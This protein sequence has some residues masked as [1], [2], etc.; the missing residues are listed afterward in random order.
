MSFKFKKL[1]FS[2]YMAKLES[3]V[4]WL[5]IAILW[6]CNVLY[7]VV[8]SYQLLFVLSSLSKYCSYSL[9]SDYRYLC[10]ININFTPFYDMIHC[11]DPP[12]S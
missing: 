2:Y 7:S 6:M 10:I 11:I 12:Y 9:F 5:L 8:G 4:K 3:R 1:G